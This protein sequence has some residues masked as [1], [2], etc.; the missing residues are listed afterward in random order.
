[1]TA[2]PPNLVLY[3]GECG[4]CS[5]A[6]QFILDHDTAGTFHLAPLQ[7]DTA[8]E[9]RAR[10]PEIPEGLDSILVVERHQDRETVAWESAAVFALARGLPFPWRAAAW[11]SWVP[12]AVGD[13]VY[14][15][16]A[17]NR[18]SVFGVADSCR[19]PSEAEAER[20]LP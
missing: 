4:L 20:L 9:V 14:R 5:L 6:V 2:P 10:H 13:P 1:M 11:F 19:M 8:A 3:D 15:L 17:R 12:R 7:G 18:L 16:I